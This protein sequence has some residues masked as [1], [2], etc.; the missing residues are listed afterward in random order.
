MGPGFA[1]STCVRICF[2]GETSRMRTWWKRLWHVVILGA[3]IAVSS[4]QRSCAA[5]SLALPSNAAEWNL[6][7]PQNCVKPTPADL[8]IWRGTAGARRVCRAEYGNSLEMKLTIFDMPG[9]PGATAFDAFQK[10]QTQPRKMAF[11]K[12]RCFGVV[13]SPTADRNPL[14]RFT[15]AVEASLPPGDEARR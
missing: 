14:D 2:T 1:T 11:Y 4:E 7:A 8:R 15:I 12:G 10:W 13:E 5:P 6:A 9:W 3:A